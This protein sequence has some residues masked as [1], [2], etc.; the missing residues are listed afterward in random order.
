[1]PFSSVIR[2]LTRSPLTDE[3]ENKLMRSHQLTLSGL[4]RV[5]KGIVSSTLSQRQESLMLVITS[6]IEE[7]GRWSVQ[8]ETM[9][10]H[11]VHYYPTSDMLPYEP[12]QPESE[13]IWGQMQ[14]LAD[15]ADWQEQEGE[16]KKMAIVATDRALQKHLPSPQK[17]NE[18]CVMLE[19]GSEIKLRDL[20]TNL[21][22]MGYENT[23]TV[24]VE[25]Q[26][27]RRGD[28]IDIFPVSS[29]MPVR[30]DWFGDE[31]ER[32]REFE[33]TT[34]RA[35]DSIPSVL[36]TPITYGHILGDEPLSDSDLED[37][38]SGKG[39]AVHPLS[40]ASLLDYLPKPE[41]C[42]VVIDE[43]EQCQAHCDRWYESAT[44]IFT[45][46]TEILHRSFADCL[47]DIAKF[48]R[49]DLF[50]LAEENRGVNMASR[51][52]PAIP[53][54]FAKI[55]QTIREYREQKY[56]I[57]L[58]SAQPSRTVA[59]L[60]EHDCQAQ[61]IPNVRD[62]PAIDKTHN[63]RIA[64]AF[65]YSGTAEIQ[66]FVLPTYRIVVISDREFFGQHALGTPNYVRKRRRA[67]SKQ[68]DLN[69]LAP[70]DYVVHKNHG[71]G[72][73]LKLEKLTVN[74]ET[75][76]YLVL[77]YDD[78]LLRVVV[79]QMS[80]LSR[81]R[82]MN[83]SKPE[84]HKMTGK[85]WT[86]TTNKAKKAIKKIAFDL[87]ELY[88]KR[89]Q[90]VGYA[91]PPDNPWQQEMED[92]FPYQATPDQLKATQDVKQ[93]MES[94]RPMDR[95]VCGDVGFGKTE[96]AIRTIFKAVTTG[97]Q[98]ALLVP[99]TILAQQ[100]YHSLQERYAAYPINIA[101][102]NRFRTKV[103]KKEIC[104]KLKTGEL[105]IVVGTHQLLSKDVEFKD[106]GLLVID[107]EQRFG[108][109]QKEK[110]KTMKT[111]VDVLTL[112]ATPIPRTL[113]MAMSGV[114]EMSLITTPPPSRRSIMTHLSRYNPELVRA[115]IR[116]EL[117]RGG[118]IFYVVSRIDDIEEVSARVHE[119]LPSVRMAIAHG[120]MPESE[121]ESTM[122]NFSSG[123]SDMMI[124]TTIIESG[125]DIPRV[126][127]IIIE[128]AQR[129]GLAQLY[130]LRG[131][132]GR[133]GIQAHAWLFYQ[134]KGELTDIA[135]KRLKAIQEF[136]H[137]GSG[138][139]LAM[140]DM[141]IRGVGNLLGAEQSGQINT[142]GFDLYMEMLQ[143]AI[144]EIRG[145]EIPE[146]EDTQVDLPITAFIPTEYIP[147]GDR[148][149]SAYRTVASVSSR[150]ELM[151]II[152]EWRDCYGKVPVPAMQLIKVM[153][154]KLLA[155]RIGFFR[156]KPEG[157]QHVVLESKMEEPAWKLLHQHLPSHLQP[158]FVY[159][160]GNVTVRG[161]GTLSHDK[162]LDNLIE[163][164]DTM[165]LAKSE[166]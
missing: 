138:Y 134:E 86:N 22:L 157:K 7:A 85:A 49:L 142:I 155:K 150:R 101:L 43:L 10:W 128:D 23:S 61:F 47:L 112:S 70:G 129:F 34:Q 55:A 30:I 125:L 76:E 151:Q 144:A 56:K 109:A 88:A 92:S 165:H 154:L 95:L 164:L 148:K 19:V 72:Q 36:L 63:L 48:N 44:E 14:V 6:T 87:L 11:I 146:V 123:E 160:K 152:E 127:T 25:G 104:R 107:E 130:Q 65:K 110:I 2:S 33:P 60:Q 105:D 162:Q 82:G 50:E 159:S 59:L 97:K 147:D 27:A 53:H 32:I 143:E 99:T 17:F 118:Q 66:G 75:R 35:L 139:Q 64:V 45:G 83:E 21:T 161:L 121:L 140:R 133:A 16:K 3:L 98:A 89:S 24:E 58:V 100:H 113:Y 122:L 141:E 137:L 116:Q 135:R 106:L 20:A 67:V 78:G 111:E 4:S 102:L 18:Y 149:M 156:I 62:F 96:V 46:G 39:F 26:W 40:S 131:R 117:D 73:F 163:W 136:T 74:N 15:L 158:R 115:A 79:D 132:V 108:V 38:F 37:E 12:Y 68:V 81:Y 84:L 13:V 145:S 42:L 54:Q 166:A 8:L 124:C 153:E 51:P 114:R 1:M 103:E 57:I 126:N 93:D 41:Q 120:Q 52:V 5:G 9:G 69:K 29:E 91:F 28:I 119:M 80:I 77:K 31:I 94:S 90:Q 71:V